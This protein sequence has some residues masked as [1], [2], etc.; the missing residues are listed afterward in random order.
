MQC[1]VCAMYAMM[2]WVGELLMDFQVGIS[3]RFGSSRPL[4][5][6]FLLNVIKIVVE[7]R[8]SGPPRVLKLWLGVCKGMHHVGHFLPQQNFLC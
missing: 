3:Q 2:Y 7:V 5:L 4:H 8:A 6:V 1:I